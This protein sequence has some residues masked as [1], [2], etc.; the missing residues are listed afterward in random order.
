MMQAIKAAMVVMTLVGGLANAG[1]AQAIDIHN[2]DERGYTAT[3]TSS[4]I[5]T[6]I[7][8]PARTLSFVISLRECVIDIAGVGKVRASQHDVIT[9]RDGRVTVTP[10]AAPAPFPVSVPAE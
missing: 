5:D 9:I 8:L 1:A 2:Q 7:D 4:A 10:G 3:V 6:D